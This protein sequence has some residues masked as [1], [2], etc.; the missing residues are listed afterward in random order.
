[1]YRGARVVCGAP[2]G[3]RNLTCGFQARSAGP[4]ECRIAQVIR[5]ARYQ[6]GLRSLGQLQTV[7][8]RLL[9]TRHANGTRPRNRADVEPR[10]FQIGHR[11][12]AWNL[13]MVPTL[14]PAESAALRSTAYQSQ[15]RC[16]NSKIHLVREMRALRQK[17]AGKTQRECRAITSQIRSRR[18]AC[19]SRPQFE[20]R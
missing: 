15:L 4:G 18:M 6:T 8:A 11:G 12:R 7:S 5:R 3:I 13:S 1:M 10:A 14:T 17:R 9:H 16:G 2:K 20:T 19:R